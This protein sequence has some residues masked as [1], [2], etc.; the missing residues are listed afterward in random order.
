M[1]VFVLKKG[2]EIGEKQIG[3]KEDNIHIKKSEK[4]NY[5]VINNPKD[6]NSI[7][8][9]KEIKILN[10]DIPNK[11]CLMGGEEELYKDIEET[12]IL[13]KI[14]IF[15]VKIKQEEKEDERNL[16]IE[17]NELLENEECNI[18]K[19]SVLIILP[20]GCLFIKL[21]KEVN[22]LHMNINW[23]SEKIH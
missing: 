9:I 23:T 16:E 20:K 15:N 18:L 10:K 8:T 17:T 13:D 2:D 11:L 6:S 5:I 21:D 7:C 19:N 14:G 4:F 3:E 22:D 1:K 12:T